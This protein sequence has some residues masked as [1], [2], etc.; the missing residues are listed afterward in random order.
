MLNLASDYR[1]AWRRLRTTPLFTAFAIA[2]LA[3][4][5]GVTT[6]V[7]SAVRAVLSPPTGLSHV[8]RLVRVSRSDA[9]GPGKLLAWP[10]YQDFESQQSVFDST[11]AWRFTRSNVSV[12]GQTELANVEFISGGYFETLG[13]T[14]QR[15]RVLQDG[16][17]QPAAPSV[18][19][20]SHDAWRRWFDA[21]PG[22]VGQVIKV[23]GT[24][25]TIVG[26]ADPE[27]VGLA[28]GGLMPTAVW[29][30]FSGARSLPGVE[31]TGNFDPNDHDH[32]WMWV[33]ARLAP[34]RTIE[35]A[36]AQVVA[37]GA[38]LNE[39]Y[40]EDGVRSTRPAPPWTARLL[41]DL[42]KG[43]GTDRIIGPLT[44]TLM[45][46]VLLVLLVA[47]TNLAN[48]MLSRTSS[49][50]QEFAVRLSLGAS[51][52]R[53]VREA[54]S[55]AVL[56][57]VVGGALAIG[58]ARLLIVVLG[59]ELVITKGF[60]LQLQ[61]RV[62][63]PVLAAG[64]LAT[65]LA[66]LAAGLAPAIYAGRADIRRALASDNPSTASPRWR[67]RRYLIALQVAVS[68]LLVTLAGL[69]VAQVR[70]HRQTEIGV[71]FEDLALVEVDFKHPQYDAAT[72]RQLVDNLLGEVS[73]QP[74][75][76]AAS[77][78][79]G[80]PSGIGTPG[81]SIRVSGPPQE[82]DWV[83]GTPKTMETLGVE[84][85]RGR[86]IDERD[87]AGSLPVVILGER[88]AESLFGTT[89][90]LGRTVRVKRRRWEGDP[91]WPEQVL[92]VVGVA[93]PAGRN[94]PARSGTIY[95]P[96][97]QQYEDRVVFATHTAGNDPRALVNTLRQI[98]QATA[99]DAA[100]VQSLTGS[101]LVAQ[102]TL[103]FQVVGVIATALG[104][105]ALVVALAGLYGIL[106]FLVAARTRE[107][108]IRMAIGANVHVIRRQILWE[109]LSPVVDGLVVGLGLGALVRLGI[110]P[111]FQKMLPAMD[112]VALGVAPVLFLV[113][114]AVACYLP[115]R[116][117]SRVNPTVALRQ[118]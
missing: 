112:F 72:V 89:D 18:A 16:D 42:P 116:R 61:P 101:E 9:G 33:T 65:F 27:F 54:I 81:A 91:E 49:R 2:T 95:V 83:A 97:T 62:D 30:T 38:R 26:V 90:V 108:G 96:W 6:G 34:G 114:G 107:I 43:E 63:L 58:V 66:M 110:Q 87:V 15:G 28:N 79:S 78:S 75:V 115:A 102:D 29:I 118:L 47:C 106:S 73:R 24:A 3:L 20:I 80:L 31:A 21:A 12:S 36:R 68:A 41:T 59:R 35:Q 53:V 17:D 48:L 71:N 64:T 74:G 1:F 86:G 19:V 109:G 51:R 40:P 104:A 92:T 111:M 23:K 4:G 77:A 45:T 52:W 82:V 117:A 39:A 113:A 44:A 84:I 103:F 105:M 55:E 70:E 8:E 37:I 22:A 56:I 11:A 60:A 85:R 98:V 7:Y 94:T 99:P 69:C 67:G 14:V 88:N 25:F 57:A 32:R 13:A 5:I 93:E 100:V 10:E 50:G 76:A 46:A